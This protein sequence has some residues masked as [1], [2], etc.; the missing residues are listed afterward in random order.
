MS[1]KTERLSRLFR[2]MSG[3]P[4]GY[5]KAP[6]PTGSFIGGVMEDIY[7]D[8]LSSLRRWHEEFGDLIRLRFGPLISHL[9]LHPRE[10]ARVLQE[11][12][13]A[14]DKNTRGFDKLKPILG[15]GLLT[16]DG[17]LWLR[18]R[19]LIQPLFDRRGLSQYGPA[20]VRQSLRTRKR[21]RELQ[22]E[23]TVDVAREMMELALRI[24]GDTLLATDVTEEAGDVGRAISY[25]QE[26]INE[27]MFHFLDLGEKL[28]T[29]RNRRFQ[30]ELSLLN[31]SVSGMIQ[32]RR[33]TPGEQQDL[34]SRLIQARDPDTG[35]SMDDAQ[36]RDEIM[37]I[38]LAGHET[39]ANALS[40]TWMLLAQ[41]PQV[42]QKVEEEVDRVCGGR[43]PQV[44]DLP[45]LTYLHQ[46]VKESLRLYP[47]AWLLERSALQAME[48]GDI[49]IP[50]GSVIIL[51]PYLT[52]RH[53]DLWPEP[54]Q[55]R[56]ER[57]APEKP[58]DRW[59]WFPFGGGPRSCI[60]NHF[61]M[62]EIPLVLATL[63]GEFQLDLEGG[64]E[65]ELEPL[66][67]LRPKGGL[68]M[69]VRLRQKSEAGV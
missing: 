4:K 68:P 25:L 21:W 40:W 15:N 3:P 37:T 9:L 58:V 55:F 18:Q 59:A 48:V 10:I 19:R 49:F 12:H 2:A 8:P 16:S 27:R 20:M 52:H 45:E 43:P 63:M 53:P 51:C 65:I 57:F 31:R 28:P 6:G 38:F 47:P 33:Q 26:E 35:A 69:K 56:P 62:M 30:K 60:G 14:F 44:E 5:R 7:R 41:H 67:T 46:V 36:L 34:V 29:P 17:D 54:D 1:A 32:Q 13:R 11:E 24:V 66:V 22:G 42:R 50:A 61:A 39:T 23:P 64:Q